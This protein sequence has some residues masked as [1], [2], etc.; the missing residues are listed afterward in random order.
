[1]DQEIKEIAYARECAEKL[2]ENF[3]KY[4]FL[5]DEKGKI[6]IRYSCPVSEI[7]DDGLEGPMMDSEGVSMTLN[8]FDDE[9]FCM[10]PR[11]D[12]HNIQAFKDLDIQEVSDMTSDMIVNRFLKYDIAQLIA[13]LRRGYNYT[14][15]KSVSGALT[16]GILADLIAVAWQKQV[17]MLL[18]KYEGVDLTKQYKTV[19][20]DFNYFL[21]DEFKESCKRQEEERKKKE[22][23]IFNVIHDSYTEEERNNL[24]STRLINAVNGRKEEN[25]LPYEDIDSFITIAQI[26]AGIH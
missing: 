22:D 8:P 25:L 14:R 4:G 10:N 2:I 17:L 11:L 9:N 18:K 16:D 6:E 12:M 24:M 15:M 5:Y 3:D 13:M 19:P 23:D 20:F 1:M 26:W 21:S 7:L